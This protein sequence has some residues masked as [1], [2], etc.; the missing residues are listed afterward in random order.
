[1]G[2]KKKNNMTEMKICV[3]KASKLC[4][5]PLSTLCLQMHHSGT[6]ERDHLGLISIDSCVPAAAN[7]LQ[8]SL[9]A[10]L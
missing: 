7:A 2:D 10:P 4:R 3:Q 8:L 9:R 1:M 6:I 5:S